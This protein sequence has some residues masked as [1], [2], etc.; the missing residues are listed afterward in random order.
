VPVGVDVLVVIAM[1][2]EA[3]EE[4]GLI[5]TELGLKLADALDGRFEAENV[6]VLELTPL[7]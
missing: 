4:L 1:V 2:V 7:T 5:V 6:I 3:V